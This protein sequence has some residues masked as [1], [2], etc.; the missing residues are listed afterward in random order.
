MP[1]ELPET[2][3]AERGHSSVTL[4]EVAMRAGV[5]TMTVSRVL[6]TPDRVSA[7]L[8]ERVEDAVRTLGYVPNLMANGLRSS[9]SHLVVALVPTISGSLFS[10]MIRSLTESLEAEGFQLM[11][12]QIGYRASREDDLLRAIVGRRPDGI[13]LTGILHSEEGRGM[14][15]SSGIPVVETWD[16]TDDPIDMLLSLSHEEIGR[17]VCAHLHD[18]GKRRLAVFTGEDERAERR[19]RGFLAAAAERGLDAP[20]V[21]WAESPTTHPQGRAALAAMADGGT[22]VDGVF[23]SS[24]MMA[25]GVLTEARA[26]GIAVP[27]QLA[28]VGFGDLEFAASLAPALTT[29]GIDGGAIGCMAARM[30]AARAGGGMPQQRIVQVDF[31]I[32]ARES[33]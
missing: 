23:C 5:S 3:H 16:A 28:V 21:R 4:R 27:E 11:V 20:Q 14:L 32:V 15:I 24:D 26:R 1:E 12:G 17:R 31:S 6:R 7:P 33:A 29:V 9:R 2:F 8:R 13:V 19:L 25:A 30:I 10:G 22:P 18:R